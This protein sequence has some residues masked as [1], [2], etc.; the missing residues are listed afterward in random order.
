MLPRVDDDVLSASPLS[1]ASS[2]SD[3][4]SLAM[5]TSPIQLEDDA[6]NGLYVSSDSDVMDD[7]SE[8]KADGTK[9]LDFAHRKTRRRKTAGHGWRG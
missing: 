4:P 9:Q 7:G 6:G 2:L 3:R 5:E 1:A 8:G